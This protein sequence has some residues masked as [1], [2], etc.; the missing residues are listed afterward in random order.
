MSAPPPTLRGSWRRLFI[1]LVPENDEMKI[2]YSGRSVDRISTDG[3]A[4]DYSS[5][6]FTAGN[7]Q[8]ETDRMEQEVHKFK[9]KDESNKAIIASQCIT[10]STRR[11]SWTNS[12]A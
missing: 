12:R 5:M 2:A 8:A 11:S 6:T 9:A 3:H 1:F 4:M 10:P 7:N